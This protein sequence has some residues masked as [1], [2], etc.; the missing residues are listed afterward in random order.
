ML[1]NWY[2]IDACFLT[3]SWRIENNGMMA[4]SC[5]GTVFLGMLIELCRRLGKEYDIFLIRQFHRQA[6]ELNPPPERKTTNA[7]EGSASASASAEPSQSDVI[8]RATA[9]Q[10]AI[11]ALLHAVT[12]GG[13]YI[14]MLL[15][16]Y[17]NG[18]IIICIFIGAALGKFFCDWLVVRVDIQSLRDGEQGNKSLGIQ[19]VTI[20]CG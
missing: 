7:E 12:F 8:M 4:A 19:E 20:C 17:F 10:Q 1:W 18:F 6:A 3:A 9:L 11:R 5:I 14:T 2:T 15:A 16:M 13:A